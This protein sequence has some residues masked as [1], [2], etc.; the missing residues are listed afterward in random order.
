MLAQLLLSGNA[1]DDGGAEKIAF[2]LGDNKTIT[3]VDVRKNKIKYVGMRKIGVA[4]VTNTT[5]EALLIGNNPVGH[6]GVYTLADKIKSNKNTALNR[7]NLDEIS[8]GNVNMDVKNAEVI[9]S[10]LSANR[11][12]T[13]L[14]VADNKFGDEGA[15][16][17]INVLQGRKHNSMIREIYL[18]CTRITDK[19]AEEFCQVIKQN[20]T[21]TR[22]SLTRNIITA[23]GIEKLRAAKSAKGK[24]G[25]AN[26]VL[27]DLDLANQ[28][29]KE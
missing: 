12:I 19:G 22:L 21:L 9:S 5:L 11:T 10:L 24:D 6:D 26:E 28:I 29:D 17:F 25:K 1:L 20:R 15:K 8:D 23:D 2:A 3:V 7:L 27:I 18:D 16:Q 4:M 14:S 13:S